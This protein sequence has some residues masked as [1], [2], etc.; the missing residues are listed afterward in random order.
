MILHGCQGL[1]FQDTPSYSGTKT[2]KAV[3][4]K[5]NEHVYLF[6]LCFCICFGNSHSC[7]QINL[8]DYRDGVSMKLKYLNSYDY[9]FNPVLV[10]K[11][12][13][14]DLGETCLFHTKTNPKEIG[15]DISIFLN[16]YL[17]FILT[18]CKVIVHFW[19]E[20]QSSTFDF[21]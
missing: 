1:C 15:A 2:S 6:S 11:T 20:I 8:S 21:L 13:I 16:S 18:Y 5:E 14:L 9:I 4:V 10:W 7:F 3:C 19:L 17:C 12:D